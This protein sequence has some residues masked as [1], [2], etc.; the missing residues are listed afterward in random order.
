MQ[1]AVEMPKAF[2]VR[3]ENEFLPFQHLMER[4]NPGLL[5]TRIATGVHVNGGPTVLWGLVHMDGHPLSQK[6]VDDAL[7]EA[8]FDF[9]HNVLVRVSEP[10][11]SDAK[12]A[13]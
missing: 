5:V 2:S 1:I 6:D 11:D 12:E 3:D 7:R 9:G 13:A 8:G 4:M 10:W